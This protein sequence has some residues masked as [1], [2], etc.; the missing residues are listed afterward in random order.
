MTSLH[1]I[2]RLFLLET[3]LSF[4]HCIYFSI[5]FIISEHLCFSYVIIL[6]DAM[7]RLEHFKMSALSWRSYVEFSSIR[8]WRIYMHIYT[9]GV[10]IGICF[11]IQLLWLRTSSC[12]IL[13]EMVMKCYFSFCRSYLLHIFSLTCYSQADSKA[14]FSLL[15]IS[16]FIFYF[17]HLFQ[18]EN[19]W[20]WRRMLL[21]CTT[22]FWSD[23]QFKLLVWRSTYIWT[24]KYVQRCRLIYAGEWQRHTQ[25]HF[26]CTYCT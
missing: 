20:M 15:I 10:N 7:P 2:P 25:H 11:C 18:C 22:N 6:L 21:E 9:T 17:L 19:I 4:S 14:L 1:P 13:K 3:S 23:C 12:E 8:F 16:L 26:C 5:Y 24:V